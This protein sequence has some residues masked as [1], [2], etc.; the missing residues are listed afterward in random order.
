MEFNFD[1]IPIKIINLKKRI[2]RKENIIK[3]LNNELIYN[4]NFI[5]AIDGNELNP[6][7]DLKLLFLNNDFGNRKG[8]IGCALSHY[9]LWQQLINDTDNNYYIIMEDDFTLSNNFKKKFESLINEYSQKDIIFLGYHMFSKNRFFFKDIYEN[10]NENIQISLLNKNLYIGGTHCYSI[11]KNGAKILLDYINNNGIKHGI[12]YLMKIVDNLQ[13]YETQPNLVFAEWNE[14]GALIDTDIQ[15][16]FNGINFNNINIDSIKNNIKVKLICNWCSSE[17][18]CLEWSNMSEN[19]F[20]WKNIEVTWNDENIDYYVIINYP[21]NN[22]YYDPKKTI[23]FQMEPKCSNNN[24]NWGIKTWGLWENPD[25]YKFLQVRTHEF[26]YNNCTSQLKI[27]YNELSSIPI[28]KRNDNY[29]STIC[30]SK[31]FDPGHI[32]RIDFLHF[33]EEKN[34]DFINIDIYGFENKHNFKNYKGSL[35]INKKENGLLPYKYYFMGENNIENNY[36]SEKF[37]EPLLCEC[38]CFYYG[39]PNVSNYINSRAFI[40]LNLE[41]FEESY[42][43]IKYS[44]KNN[45]YEERLSIIKE[46]KYKILNYYNFYPTIERIITKDLWKKKIN[47][48]NNTKIIILDNGNIY[49]LF[50]FINTMTEFGFEIDIINYINKNELKIENIDLVDNK[51]YS[52]FINKRIIYKL[53]KNTI[54]NIKYIKNNDFIKIFNHINIYEKYINIINNKNYF[55]IESNDLL[56]Y[57]YDLFFNY[58]LLLPYNYDICMLNE[59]NFENIIDNKFNYL[60]YT[61]NNNIFNYNKPYFITNNGMQKILNYSKN[62][63]EYSFDRLFYNIYNNIKDLNIYLGKNQTE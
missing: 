51:I 15:Y 2:D 38:L 23:I 61:I 62:N 1:K 59:V 43:I 25:P 5:E 41:N 50:P 55:I 29:I 35:P 18:L 40:Q 22:E 47:F 13:C 53:Y 39:A 3:I 49:K 57:S 37:W 31:Y 6:T 44:I 36:I 42:N 10:D 52:N 56:E 34:D 9:Y 7:I 30:S 4:Y 46:E 45:L 12:D 33:L 14:N 11:N 19:L 17:Q 26:Y 24:Q 16:D 58:I 28:I 48:I 27:N 8:V 60:Y 20:K 63:I 21:S 54:L 32:K